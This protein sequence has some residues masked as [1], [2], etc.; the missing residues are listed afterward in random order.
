MSKSNKVSQ[1]FTTKKIAIPI[2]IGLVVAVY[3]LN[4]NTDWKEFKKVEWEWRSFLWMLGGLMMMVLR[5]LAYMYRIKVLT[6][7]QVNWRN[8]FDVI[9]LWE[10]SS[11]VTPGIVG[12]TG[13]ALYILKK[14]GL[15]VGKSTSTIM[16]TALFDQLFYIVTVPLIILIVGTQNLFPVELQKEIF[17]IVFSV[18]GLFIIGF[19]V[20][21]LFGAL[22][23]YGIFVHPKGLKK[24]LVLIFKISFLKRWEHKI[25]QVGDEIIQT[26]NEFRDKSFLFWL[27]ASMATLVSWAAR[28]C[29]INFL[30]LAFTPVG[31]H[32]LIYARQL[33]M[34]IVMIISPT[35][36]GVGVA[37]FAFNGFLAE[38]TPLGLAGLLAVLWRLGS[39]YPYLII[40]LLI[41][42][43]WLKKV[44]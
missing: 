3:M 1:L 26:A 5:D 40:G 30:I 22:F 28:F 19:T 39:Y 10:F 42:P 15:S 2:I 41:L 12:G 20:T 21:L 37:E 38:F 23:F 31:D 44:Y 6:S 43:K 32:L 36:G 35:P 9:M 24:L 14:E 7:E 18:K 34:W 8:S 25:E 13:V 4:A 16:L 17:G 29:L 11:A 27:K 33:V